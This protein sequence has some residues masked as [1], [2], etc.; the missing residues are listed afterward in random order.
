MLG[1]E[2]FLHTLKFWIPP[3]IIILD[4][5]IQTNENID[6]KSLTHSRMSISNKK[7]GKLK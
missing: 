7:L 5:S 1:V 3:Y 6:D 2:G 4:Y